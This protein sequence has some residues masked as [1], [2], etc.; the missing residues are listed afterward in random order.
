MTLTEW[1]N[2]GWLRPH[3]SS[4]N[5]IE[6]LFSIVDRD[7]NDAISKDL[8]CDWKFGIDTMPR[9]IS[10]LFCCMR[11]DTVQKS[12]FNIS[13]R[14]Q[15]FRKSSARKKPTRLLILNYVE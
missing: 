2:N 9:S 10:A 15:L 12:Y 5:E 13:E 4:R 1:Q 14:L 11:Q 6:G 3:K 8:S 7:L